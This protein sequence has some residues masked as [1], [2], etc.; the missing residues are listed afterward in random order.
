MELDHHQLLFVRQEYRGGTGHVG[1]CLC[2]LD[3]WIYLASCCRPVLSFCALVRLGVSG[4]SWGLESRLGG[5]V[6]TGLAAPSS[7]VRLGA[8]SR[9]E[10]S[11]EG[12]GLKEF[13][14]FESRHLLSSDDDDGDDDED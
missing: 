3:G 1:L 6:R 9:V 4:I 5:M 14:E 10:S 7:R 2:L 11:V 13:K 12:K 8:I